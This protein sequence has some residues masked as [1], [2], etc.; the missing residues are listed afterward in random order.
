MRIPVDGHH[1]IH[2]VKSARF[3]RWLAMKFFQAEKRVP[4]SQALQ[5]ALG[6]CEGQALFNPAE[7]S[8]FLR[9]AEHQDRIYLDL[10]NQDWS[11]VEITAEGWRIVK[12]P[13]VRFR[14]APGMLSLP[15][16]LTGGKFSDLDRFLNIRSAGDLVLAKAWLVAGMRGWGPYPV[17]AV[18]GGQG[19]A[20]STFARALRRLIDPNSVELRT[21]PREERDLMIAAQNGHVIAFDNVSHLPLWLSDGLCRLAT[22]GGFATWALF[23]DED[24]VLIDAVRPIIF[25]GIEELATRGDLLERSIPLY[26]PEI[27]MTKR[28]P[29][30]EFWKGFDQAWPSML[31][32]L[33]TAV[34]AALRELPSVKMKGYPRMADFAKWSV[35]AE[36]Y[37]G[38]APGKFLKAYS[39][40]QRA[41]ND[42]ALEASAVAPAILRLLQKQSTWD[43]TAT[44]LLRQLETHLGTNEATAKTWPRSPQ[45]LS[46][47]LRRLTKNLREIGISVS[48]GREA[49]TGM[50]RITVERA[51]PDYVGISSSQPSQSRM[52]IGFETTEHRHDSAAPRHR[53]GQSESVC[54]DRDDRDDEIPRFSLCAGQTGEV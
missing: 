21:P 31:G 34:S 46:N 42:I 22:G 15:M 6:M 32:G 38:A 19:T 41:A 26:L 54:D 49:G 16:P 27:P 51:D 43:G 39:K 44:D 5:D 4:T 1:E 40:N 45:A 12:E 13:P 35:A 11:A 47:A 10:G 52:S 24:E 20:K 29:E 2:P 7:E 3:R 50:R 28:V 8:V 25:D 18:H 17:L 53:W 37:L 36:F 14:R 33:L 9:I 48:F 23:T 30:E